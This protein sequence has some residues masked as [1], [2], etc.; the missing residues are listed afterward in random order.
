ME[1]RILEARQ[2]ILGALTWSFLGALGGSKSSHSCRQPS[3]ERRRLWTAVILHSQLSRAARKIYADSEVVE[4]F[5][6]ILTTD[7]TERHG[8]TDTPNRF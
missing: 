7:G 2:Q 1:N 4:G 3:R 6:G 8:F 5:M